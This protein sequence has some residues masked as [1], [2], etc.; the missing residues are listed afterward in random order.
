MWRK[1][2]KTVLLWMDTDDVANDVLVWTGAV[3]ANVTGN[4]LVWTGAGEV[5]ARTSLRGLAQ[6]V[7]Q[8]AQPMED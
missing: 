2:L 6:T 7:S 3:G 1:M 8:T 4:V 5:A